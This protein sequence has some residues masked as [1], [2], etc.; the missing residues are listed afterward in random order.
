MESRTK[1]KQTSEQIAA[2]A[3]A[4][5][6]QGIQQ[7]TELKEGWFNVAYD[8]TLNDHRS[9]I[10][11][12][13]PPKNAEVMTYEQGMMRSE[14]TLMK[15][16]KEVI[17][18]PCPI[19]YG[20]DDSHQLCDADYFFM[21]KLQGSNFEH[22]KSEMTPIELATIHHQIGQLTA[23]WN[24]YTSAT[25]FGY[26]HLPS[27]QASTWKEAFLKMVQAVLEDGKRH[28]VDI[29]F[30]YPQIE[31]LYHHFSSVLDE[32]TRPHFVHW[33]CWDS[34]VFVA[35]KKVSGILDFERGFFG[36]PLA[37]ALFRMHIPEQLAGYQK[38]SFTKN[39]ELRMRLY[40]G[41]LFL[42]MI[43]EDSYRHYDNP[44]IRNYGFD[45]LQR[46]VTHLQSLMT[47]NK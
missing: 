11:K 47:A 46:L 12:I 8:V 33:D 22:I 35:D 27:L 32:V 7:V 1:N 28:Q 39:E 37:E 31:S 14:V 4:I 43:I 15:L 23:Q 16:A 2:M 30:P 9:V 19:I 29:G 45:S 40:D 20:Y 26:A 38:T 10:L 18:I 25:L 44:G 6:H 21:E 36:D 3:Q 13:A 41:Y 34:N 17:G 5:F 42:I 24:T